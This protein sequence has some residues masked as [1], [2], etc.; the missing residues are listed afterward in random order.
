M[1]LPDEL[2]TN[3]SP[4]KN[5]ALG[6]GTFEASPGDSDLCETAV[7]AALHAGYRFIDTAA[8][9]GCEE[10]VGRG[11]KK[12]GVPREEVVLCT[13]LYVCCSASLF[14]M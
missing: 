1:G 10:A 12:S 5:P 4:V 8:F 3:S 7:I 9:Y 6:L 13:K 2:F 14:D 11:I